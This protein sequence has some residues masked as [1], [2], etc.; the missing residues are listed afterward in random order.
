MAGHEDLPLF[1]PQHVNRTG[2]ALAAKI[3]AAG[4]PRQPIWKTIVEDHRRRKQMEADEA[5]LHAQMVQIRDATLRFVSMVDSMIASGEAYAF[6]FKMYG[7]HMY[8][9]APSTPPAT[10][11]K[12]K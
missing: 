11:K 7:Q 8:G 4:R 6:M 10:G 9:R 5:R 3:V 1:P 12:R 2:M